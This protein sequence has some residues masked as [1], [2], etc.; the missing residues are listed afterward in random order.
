MARSPEAAAKHLG[1]DSA[2]ERGMGIPHRH[3]EPGLSWMDPSGSGQVGQHMPM[4]ADP[5]MGTG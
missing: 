5:G 4:V 1:E 3:L 2:R